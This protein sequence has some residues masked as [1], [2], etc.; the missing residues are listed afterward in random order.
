MVANRDRVP[1]LF[2]ELQLAFAP[3]SSDH[4]DEYLLRAYLITAWPLAELAFGIA[5]SKLRVRASG[6]LP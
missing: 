5:I 6:R 2:R 4:S 1:Q 3:I